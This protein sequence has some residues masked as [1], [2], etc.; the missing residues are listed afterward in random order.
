MSNNN[1]ERLKES[2]SDIFISRGWNFG[3]NWS[4]LSFPEE[5]A[6]AISLA[7]FHPFHKLKVSE[8]L[9]ETLDYDVRSYSDYRFQE[10]LSKYIYQAI[11]LELG[12]LEP[13]T[14]KFYDVYC[15]DVS[16]HPKYL[17]CLYSFDYVINE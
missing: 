17:G 10:I 3:G 4:I 6:L 1:I 9:K 13:L 12:T 15:H 11:A 7:D 16:W 5:N 2:V 8:H 14:L